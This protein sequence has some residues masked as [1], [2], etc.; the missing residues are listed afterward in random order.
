MP[1]LSEDDL[2][3]LSILASHA[4]EITDNEGAICSVTGEPHR[5]GGRGNE[6]HD[7]DRPRYSNRGRLGKFHDAATPEVVQSLLREVKRLREN[8]SPEER[9][10]IARAVGSIERQRAEA[11]RELR[12]ERAKTARLEAELAQARGD[13]PR[14]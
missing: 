11:W 8:P 5:F 2:N 3:N 9:A 13:E 7:C 10:G 6:C 12:E 1:D 14:E 4:R